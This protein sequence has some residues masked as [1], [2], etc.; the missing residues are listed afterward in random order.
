MLVKLLQ[1]ASPSAQFIDTLNLKISNNLSSKEIFAYKVGLY[2][3]TTARTGIA[4][5]IPLFNT[6]FA[7][8]MAKESKGKVLML[9]RDKGGIWLPT[10]ETSRIDEYV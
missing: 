10:E 8:S 5:F 3:T 7:E 1:T 9:M 4:G 2:C 6:V